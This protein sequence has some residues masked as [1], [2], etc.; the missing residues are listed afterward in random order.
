MIRRPPRSTL[1]PYTTLFRSLPPPPDPVPKP[2]RSVP[3]ANAS[4]ETTGPT[5]GLDTRPQ[6]AGAGQ[7]IQLAAI[8]VSAPQRQHDDETLEFHAPR[9]ARIGPA[10]SPNSRRGG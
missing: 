1:F 5:L 4:G 3:V 10:P 9:I 6:H 2:V 7:L 8:E